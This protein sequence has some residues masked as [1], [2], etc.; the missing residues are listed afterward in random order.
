MSLEELR[1]F[2][3]ERISQTF[4]SSDDAV[5]EHLQT[6]M[7]E[8]RRMKLDLPPPGAGKQALPSLL[9]TVQ[10]AHSSASGGKGLLQLVFVHWLRVAHDDVTYPSSIPSSS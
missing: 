7:T 8:L 9:F 2:L 3:Q 6:A 10:D 5:V 1:E 4:L